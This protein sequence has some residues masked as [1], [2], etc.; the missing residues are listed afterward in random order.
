MGDDDSKSG[1]D[2]EELSIAVIQEATGEQNDV[3]PALG[4]IE[5][6]AAMSFMKRPFWALQAL[7]ML[8][9]YGGLTGVIVGGLGLQFAVVA[10]LPFFTR[11]QA[12]EE[13][14]YDM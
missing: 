4:D 13:A 8:C 7:S 1:E 5:Y 11:K 2:E 14:S 3:H 9:L 12:E 6:D 10:L